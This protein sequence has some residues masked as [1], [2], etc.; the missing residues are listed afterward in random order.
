MIWRWV[1]R[2]ASPRIIGSHGFIKTSFGDGQHMSTSGLITGDD[3]GVS[4]LCQEHLPKSIR[5][6]RRISGRIT[7]AYSMATSIKSCKSCGFRSS[8]GA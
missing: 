3:S 6:S 5:H 7:S 8:H 1:D 4:V 2:G